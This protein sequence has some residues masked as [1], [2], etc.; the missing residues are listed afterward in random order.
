MSDQPIAF[1]D[2]DGVLNRLCSGREAK[3]RGLVHRKAWCHNR[4]F[5]LW[6]DP[7]DRARLLSL[8]PMFQLAWGT[9]WEHDANHGPGA[10][11]HLPHLD[12]VATMNDGE[13]SKA[14]G[15]ERAADGR[16]FVWFDDDT[17]PEEVWAKQDHL[18][19]NIDPDEGLADRHI[20]QAIQWWATSPK[21]KP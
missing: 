3:R 11:L 10:L 8:T 5:G 1:I 21:G 9:T 16:P 14:G 15:V 19:I 2:V 17:A 18:V 12:L 4:E 13:S 7:A 6:M 20:E